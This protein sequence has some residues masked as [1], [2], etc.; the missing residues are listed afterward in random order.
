MH[1]PS[2]SARIE[3]RLAGKKP[4]N[5]FG[6]LF[7]GPNGF[8]AA[9]LA[10]QGATLSGILRDLE[11]G[12]LTAVVLVECDSSTWSPKAIEAIAKLRLSVVLDHLSGPLEK[13]AGVLLPTRATYESEGSFVNRAG[14]LQA[15]APGRTPG[16]P[17]R[18]QI[19]LDA[20]FPRAYRTSAAG[21]GA[22]NA[23]DVLEALREATFGRPEARPLS[24]VRAAL[25]RTQPL[26]APLRDATPGSDGLVLDL[27]A[28]AK[29]AA[30]IPAFAAAGS[31][32][33]AFRMD[34]TLGSE[35]LSRRSAP[36]QKA[37][38]APVA[39]LS[40]ADAQ[41]LGVK[42][43][44]GVTVAGETVE[45]RARVHER[46][47]EGTLIVPR[48]VAWPAGVPQGAPVQVAAHALA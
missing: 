15:F 24:E 18:G 1:G 41:K 25:G 7:G 30:E 23:W 45:L 21:G 16:L 43:A 9:A 42:D 28:V 13:A 33:A 17:V 12:A 29:R 44:I 19:A 40:P 26:W 6:C 46:V 27:G 8:G 47:P 31:G 36:M 48:D 35:L 32:L 22:R 38:A 5:L 34:R 20:D 11:A 2:C 10:A 4:A 39:L 3:R 37:A 14:R